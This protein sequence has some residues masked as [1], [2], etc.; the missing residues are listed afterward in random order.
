MQSGN[1]LFL[2]QDSVL[3]HFHCNV[4]NFLKTLCQGDGLAEADQQCGLLSPWI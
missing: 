4:T 3:P 2:Q 1:T